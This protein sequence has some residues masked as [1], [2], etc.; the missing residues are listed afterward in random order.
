MLQSEGQI[1]RA[2]EV[3]WIW[4]HDVKATKKKSIKICLK[5]MPCVVF[6][7]S[8]LIFSLHVSWSKGFITPKKL[9]VAILYNYQTEKFLHSL[10]LKILLLELAYNNR[11]NRK[12][13]NRKEGR[14]EKCNIL[15]GTKILK[16][17][18]VC[19]PLTVRQLK[20]R[21]L[22][23][24]L[25]FPRSLI[26]GEAKAEDWS[27]TE[28]KSRYWSQESGSIMGETISGQDCLVMHTLAFY[29]NLNFRLRLTW[30]KVTGPLCSS[31]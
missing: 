28:K 4:M 9:F 1:W 16:E 27:L 13:T 18:Y 17:T 12:E 26:L 5:K 22:L 6:K 3:S 14:V 29:L 11:K 31:S 8:S 20:Q 23:R 15:A 25:S 30:C 10:E 7:E 24:N 21:T 2:R 19:L